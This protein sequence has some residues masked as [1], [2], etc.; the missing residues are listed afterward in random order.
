MIGI[1]GIGELRRL[2]IE[3]QELLRVVYEYDYEIIELPDESL[4]EMAI[5]TRIKE[6]KVMIEDLRNAK[7]EKEE[8]ANNER[9]VCPGK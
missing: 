6:L 4:V 8:K 3:H 5:G 2:S 7:K 1:E 9:E